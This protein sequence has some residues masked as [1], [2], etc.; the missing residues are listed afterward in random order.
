M[1][2]SLETL[3]KRT[4]RFLRDWPEEDTIT[5]SVSSSA[6][7]ITVADESIYSENWLL[8]IDQENMTVTGATTGTT[9]DV[10]R[11]ARGSTAASHTSGSVVLIRPH[12]LYNE[13]VDAL[14]WAKDECF[15][16]IYKPVSAEYTGFLSDTYEYDVPEMPGLS[17]VP[18]PYLSKLEIKPSGESDFRQI[19]GWWIKRGATPYIQFSAAPETGGTLRINGYGPF[20]DLATGGSL[21]A[22]WPAQADK[23]LPL[24]AASLLLASGEAGRV[25]VDTGVQD[26]REQANRSGSSMAASNALYNRFRR[27]VGGA[28]MRPILQ[29]AKPTF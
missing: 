7:Q 27:M 9:V 23:L 18:I 12:F 10:R 14:N 1:A 15:P 8:E 16:S 20:P 17:N 6:T 21:D 3:V 28:A 25:R 13:I 22:L 4:R 19:R 29:H 5:A 24:G 11:G 26:A 2:T